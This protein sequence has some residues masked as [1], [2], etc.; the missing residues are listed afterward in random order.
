MPVNRRRNKDIDAKVPTNLYHDDTLGTH[1]EN[2]MLIS[3]ANQWQSKKRNNTLRR[4]FRW[5][6]NQIC[7]RVFHLKLEVCMTG[8]SL[9]IMLLHLIGLGTKVESSNGAMIGQGLKRIITRPRPENNDNIRVQIN[10]FTDNKSRKLSFQKSPKPVIVSPN[11]NYGDLKLNFLAEGDNKTTWGR[12]LHIDKDEEM[13]GHVYTKVDYEKHWRNYDKYYAFDDDFVRNLRFEDKTSSCR[14]VSWH[15]LYNPNCNTFHETE[16]IPL[17]PGKNRFLGSGS[18]RAAFFLEEIFDPE[19]AIKVQRFHD[20][21]YK[22]DN[23]EFVRMDALIMERLTASPRIVDVFGHCAVSVMTEFFPKELDGLAVPWE[24]R[25]RQRKFVEAQKEQKKTTPANKLTNESKLNIALQMAEAIADLHGFKDGVLI[26]DDIQLPQFLFTGKDNIKLNDFNRGEAMLFDE[27]KGEYCRYTNGAG[28]GDWRAPEEYRDGLL[29]EKIDV[30]SYG[31]NVYSLL[32]G[33]YVFYD[34]ADYP[35]IKE[36]ILDGKKTEIDPGYRS[37]SY[38]EG[39]LVEI[40]EKCWTENPDE[41][42]SIFEIVNDLRQI[43]KESSKHV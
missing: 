22:M 7:M 4:G 28:G 9:F 21:N 6:M 13:A 26:H 32:T 14:T 10:G 38:I 15:R 39:K 12:K 24:S 29:N 19:L 1:D 20:P 2:G 18:Y 30:W 25:T 42:P 27:K 23:Y 41:R 35:E 40:I 17:K 43:K 31:N 5:K 36:K 11:A 8:L 16:I 33:L 3:N 34:V 37:R